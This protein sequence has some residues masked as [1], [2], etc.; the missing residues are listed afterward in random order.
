MAKVVRYKEWECYLRFGTYLNGQTAIEL[1]DTVEG[2]D[3][4]TATVALQVNLNENEV[5]IK[6]YE[7]NIGML[8]ALINAGVVSK[9]KRQL[10]T[11]FVVVHVCDLQIPK[12]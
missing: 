5:I 11:G 2:E 3:V 4:A 1:V 9:A 7:E 6:D 8:D 10:Q 12:G